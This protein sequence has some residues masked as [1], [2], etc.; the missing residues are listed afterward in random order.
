MNPKFKE[1]KVPGFE[2]VLKVTEEQSGLEAIIA[3]HSTTMGPALGGTRIFPHKSFDQALKDVLRLSQ[4]MTY[5]AAIAQ[6]GLGGGKSI[7]I[8]DAKKEKTPELLRA[9]GKA[10][11]LLKGEYI[12]AEDVGCTVDDVDLIRQE[13][14]Y[15]TGTSHAQASG[16][17]SPFTAWGTVR[18]MHAVMQHLHKSDSLRGKTVAIQGLGS[19]GQIIAEHLFWQG[20]RMIV[21]D[22]DEGKAERMARRFGAQVAKTDEIHASRCD[23]FAPCALGGVINSFTI[24]D[25]RCSAIA[26]CANNQLAEEYHGEFLSRKGI[27]YSPDFVINAGG[28]INVQ[29]EFEESGYDAAKVRDRVNSIYDQLLTIFNIS[30]QNK[31]STEEAAMSLADYKLRYGI[32]KRETRLKFDGKS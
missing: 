30:K 2:K 12:C 19:V 1:I 26:G 20:A 15:V 3:I 29:C 28:L 25:L 10:V 11:D 9:F 32:G 7:I 18:G 27:L 16:N 4:G 5:K 23:I 31:V 21:S 13:T 22:I 14:P 17:P 24:P 8:A 6:M